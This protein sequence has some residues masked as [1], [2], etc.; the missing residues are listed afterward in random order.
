MFSKGFPYLTLAG[1]AVPGNGIHCLSPKEQLACIDRYDGWGGR[2]IKFV[3]ASG[4]ASRMF[5][6]LFEAREM[7]VINPHAQL[8]KAALQFFEQLPQ[9]PFYPLLKAQKGFDPSN[10]KG[11][12]DL[13]LDKGGLNYG[14]LPKG[15][16]AFHRYDGTFRTAFE[17]HLVEAARYATDSQRV[18]SLHFTVSE[19]HREVFANLL[20]K[21]LPHYESLYHVTYRVA[22]STQHHA[23]DTLAV[24]QQNRPFRLADGSLLLRP[25]GHGA[26]LDNLNALDQD[27]VFIK[28][29]DN[30][31]PED[32]LPVVI[33]WKKVLAGLLLDYRKQVCGYL[34]Q[35]QAGAAPLRLK[36]MANFLASAFGVTHPPMPSE[37]YIP[38]LFAK[39]N[40]PIRVCGMVRQSGEPGGGPYRVIDKDGSGSL[41]ILE[42][43]QLPTIDAAATHF[44][45]VDL[46]CSFKAYDGSTYRLSD[47]RDDSTGF[48]SL[49]SK[50]GKELKAL[51]LPGL[52]NGSMSDWN[53]AFVEVPAETFN[54]V[55]TVNDLL[56]KEHQ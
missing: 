27:I 46:V 35:L 34:E 13:L 9:F 48:I 29:I 38:Y 14:A 20:Q 4:S 28:N 55:K 15:V 47:F 11:V 54:P 37:Q 18:A 33:Y 31:V 5:K 26:L 42:S 45:P 1:P 43:A 53:T 7:L 19:E 21:V 6:A 2:R 36:E 50:E 25:S 51:E 3:P 56:R 16:L 41:Q 49:K 44:N 30:V 24:D 52:W 8:S 23:T 22:F 40:R 32:R 12:L 10:M 39:L 17:E